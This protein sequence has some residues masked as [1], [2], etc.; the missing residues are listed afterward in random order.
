MTF[1]TVFF[2]ARK[3]ILYSATLLGLLCVVGAVTQLRTDGPGFVLFMIGGLVCFLI[4]RKH[5]EIA[6]IMADAILYVRGKRA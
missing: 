2:F 5:L 1:G 6:I 3:G 4:V